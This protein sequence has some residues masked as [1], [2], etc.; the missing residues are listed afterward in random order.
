VV[1]GCGLQ[2]HREPADLRAGTGNRLAVRRCVRRL[3]RR[4]IRVR[5]AAGRRCVEAEASIAEQPAE[6]ISKGHRRLVSRPCVGGRGSL[7]GKRGGRSRFRARRF[8]DR[9]RLEHPR[10]PPRLGH[11]ERLAAR[12]AGSSLAEIPGC[13]R[14]LAKGHANAGDR[15]DVGAQPAA[16]LDEQRRE[17]V[18]PRSSGGFVGPAG[19][20]GG[21]CARLLPERAQQL[22]R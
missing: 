13:D 20:V 7:G 8:G 10:P 15:A 14:V 11:D 4:G 19:A 16:A 6:P 18:K 1:A 2:I 3:R 5:G 17:L 12:S 9:R 21:V 22:G